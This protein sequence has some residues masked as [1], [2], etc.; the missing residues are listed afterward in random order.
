MQQLEPDFH[1]P[2]EYM[3]V[4]SIRCTDNV[5]RDFKMEE[6]CSSW[7]PSAYLHSDIFETDLDLPEYHDHNVLYNEESAVDVFD[8]KTDDQQEGSTR[9]GRLDTIISQYMPFDED[10]GTNTDGE[11]CS[12]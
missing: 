6:T 7:S 11:F 1:V 12:C 4:P 10:N 9:R 8:V 2:P 3:Y 5:D